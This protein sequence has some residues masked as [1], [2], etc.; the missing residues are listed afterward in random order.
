MRKKRK[1]ILFSSLAMLVVATMAL[2]STTFAW[3][4]TGD[5]ATIS[6]FEFTAQDASGIQFS[7][8][9]TDWKSTLTAI[10]IAKAVASKAN[11]TGSI[12]GTV[13]AG[14][15]G[16]DDSFKGLTLSPVSTTSTVTGGA[17]SMFG[18]SANGDGT[19][20]TSAATD[21]YYVFN[22]YVNN[23]GTTNKSLYLTSCTASKTGTPDTHLATRIAFLD[24][25]TFAKKDKTAAEIKAGAAALTNATTS[26]IFEPNSTT[27]TSDAVNLLGATKDVKATTN[28]VKAAGSNYK[29]TQGFITD[30]EAVAAVTTIEAYTTPIASLGANSV[31]KLTIYVWIEGQDIDCSNDIASGNVSVQMSFSTTAPST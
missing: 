20:N 29:T 14:K 26:T 1:Q 18:A 27:H 9:V 23:L 28:G 10:D 2:T 21:G 15:D 8:D 13:E 16:A 12:F 11:G 3:F 17:L 24:E 25:G 30:A 6:Q 7:A 19:M 22:V 4:T 5:T 31:T